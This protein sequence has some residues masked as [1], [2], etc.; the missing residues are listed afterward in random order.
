M[1]SFLELPREGHLD[2]LYHIFAHLEAK[3]NTEMVFDPP[4]PQIDD[5][6]FEHE[7]WKRTTYGRCAE[8]KPANMP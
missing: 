2:Q 8:E 7:D 1:A 4:Q 3:N 6:L 5:A